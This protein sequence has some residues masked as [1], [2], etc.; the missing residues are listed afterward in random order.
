MSKKIINWDELR[1]ELLSDS[2]VQASF[3]AEERKARLRDMLAQ[4]RN[5]SR[6]DACAGG[7]EDGG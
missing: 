5:Q 1:A 6:T 2:E 3:D 4:W 7:R